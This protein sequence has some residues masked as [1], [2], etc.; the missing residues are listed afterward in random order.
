M[1]RY[2]AINSH[3]EPVAADAK[4]NNIA[5]VCQGCGHRVLVSEF[6]NKSGKEECK[7]CRRAYSVTMSSE[8][9]TIVIS[10]EP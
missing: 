4:G 7:G 6:L 5:C 8:T 2:K 1:I 3:G 9:E 10:Y